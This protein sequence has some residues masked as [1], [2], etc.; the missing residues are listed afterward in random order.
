MAKTASALRTAKTKSSSAI[1]LA[2]KEGRAHVSQA[3]RRA[4]ARMH[5]HTR[6]NQLIAGG[7]AVGLGLAERSGRQLP[8]VAGIQPGLLYGAVGMLA[9]SFVPGKTGEL[10]SAAA[11][12]ALLVGG[13]KVAAGAPIMGEEFAGDIAGDDIAGDIAGDYDG[14]GE[15][16]WDR[17]VA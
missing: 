13:Y 14:L 3:V 11:F 8:S 12:G 16:A 7:A 17:Q 1:T 15:D 4:T 9:A 2:S 6:T 5:Q 10:V